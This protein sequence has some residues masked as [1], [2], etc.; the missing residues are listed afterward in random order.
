MLDP[1]VTCKQPNDHLEQTGSR[2]WADAVGTTQHTSVLGNAMDKG[3]GLTPMADHF[4]CL[5]GMDVVLPD[6]TAL[7]TG[8]GPVGNNQVRQ[9]VRVGRAVCTAI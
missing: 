1:G 4:G 6:G 7:E 9:T 3:R 8:G 2:L 5:C